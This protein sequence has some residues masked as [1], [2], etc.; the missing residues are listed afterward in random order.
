MSPVVKSVRW[1]G[2][3]CF[4]MQR[5][6]WV[7]VCGERHVVGGIGNLGSVVGG[8]ARVGPGG[9]VQVLLSCSPAYPSSVSVSRIRGTIVL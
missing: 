8:S 3:F 4:A 7:H 1:D 6:A 9:E 5:Q 2:A